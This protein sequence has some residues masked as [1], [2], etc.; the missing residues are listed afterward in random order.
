MSLCLCQGQ[1]WQNGGECVRAS[2]FHWCQQ[3]ANR[4]PGLTCSHPPCYHLYLWPNRPLGQPGI[5]KGC[6]G[7]RKGRELGLWP[8]AWPQWKK[9][10]K[11]VLSVFQLTQISQAASVLHQSTTFLLPM[12]LASPCC[13]QHKHKQGLSTELCS[14]KLLLCSVFLLQQHVV[15]LVC[16]HTNIKKSFFP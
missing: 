11:K 8:L 12:Q 7:K 13:V 16:M 15:T 9:K 1:Q 4:V 10:K 14:P 5:C 2:T 3:L 6:K